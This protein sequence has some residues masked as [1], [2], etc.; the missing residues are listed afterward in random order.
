MQAMNNTT[1]VPALE[2]QSILMLFSFD[3]R[4]IRVDK[5]S[6]TGS[7]VPTPSPRGGG[8][9]GRGGSSNVGFGKMFDNL[10]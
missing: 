6:N 7:G 3:G 8:R 10:L 5:A 9:G 1:S 2:R 4:Q